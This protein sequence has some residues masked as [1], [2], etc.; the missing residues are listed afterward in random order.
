[1]R[2]RLAPVVA[3]GTVKCARCDELI[4]AGEDWQLDHRDDGRGWLGPSHQRCNARAGWEAMIRSQNGN[5]AGFEEQPYRWSQRWFDDP[6]VGT[7]VNA[8]GGM[9]EVY[10]GSGQWSRPRPFDPELSGNSPSLTSG[11]ARVSAAVPK[12]ADRS[13]R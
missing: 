9:V 5:G 12:G 2:A 3:T 6:P 10:L 4:E 11:A 7:T 13:G 1:M 8:G